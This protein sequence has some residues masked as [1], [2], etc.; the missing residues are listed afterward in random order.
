[1]FKAKLVITLQ[2]KKRILYPAQR[3]RFT[4]SDQFVL[5]DKFFKWRGY[6]PNT[7]DGLIS[8]F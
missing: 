3:K 1:M 7:I 5:M 8:N 6:T 4:K 2:N